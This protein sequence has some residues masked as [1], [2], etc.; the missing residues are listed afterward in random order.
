MNSMNRR[1]FLQTS[2]LAAAG[3][4]LAGCQTGPRKFAAYDKL[5][6][7]IIGTANRAAS[8]INGVLGQN[9][10][11]LCDIDENYLAAAKQRFPRAKTFKDFR[12]L[13]EQPGIDAIVVST[14][15]HTHAVATVAALQSGRHVYCEKPLAHTVSE[16]R[17]VSATVRKTGRATQLGTQIHAENNYRRVVELVQSGAIGTVQ[18]VHVFVDTKY[19]MDRFPSRDIAPRNIDY[20]LWLGPVFYRTYSKEYI[21]NAWRNWWHFGGGTM[22]D[23]G[24]HHMDLAH[25]ALNLSY[26]STIEAE[27]PPVHPESV[28]QWMIVHYEYPARIHA[29]VENDLPPVKLTWYQGGKRPHY[30]EDGKLPKWGSGTLFVGSKGMLLADY[31][32]HVLL[33]EK[34][35]ADF[36]APKPFIPNSVGH[37]N[38]WM[39]ACKYGTPTSCN[40]G[41][42][43]L[44]TEAALLGNVA[45]RAGKKLKWDPIALRAENCPE[46]DQFIQHFYRPGW[47]I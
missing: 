8:N 28:P 23:F 31:S 17:I 40:F 24:C 4:W 38:E 3:T 34:D 33:P 42:G 13:L 18:E 19:G 35:F 41:Y 16:A 7:G 9:I 10:V 36:V 14:P 27:G 39:D 20:D 21:P 6:I 44:L 32:K 37:Y 11:A 12:R 5:N 22:A 43:G 1:R 30:F 46:A 26:P 25:W 2:T 29:K 45:F 47:K 15:D